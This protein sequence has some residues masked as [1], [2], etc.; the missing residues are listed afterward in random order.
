M[1]RVAL[2]FRV[3]SG[4]AIAVVVTGPALTPSAIAR[5]V[6][7]L[8]DPDDAE[9]RQPFHRGF[10]HEEEDAREIARRVKIVERC[11]RQSVT[12]LLK[13]ARLSGGLCPSAG[14]VVGSVID[15]K[16]VGNPHIR[17]HANEGLLFRRV[18]ED[19]LRSHG[20][21]CDLIVLKRL[22]ATAASGLCRSSGDVTSVVA[23]FGAALGPP[24]RADEKA[25]A[26]AAWLALAAHS[27]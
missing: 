17:A 7:E 1:K 21:G 12:A 2:G 3:K 13:E 9:T 5:R 4:Y 20:L 19:A 15:P 25:A 11:A 23:R 18:L 6:V 10:Y 24:W 8:S 16:T 26:T 14:L 22:T 27:S